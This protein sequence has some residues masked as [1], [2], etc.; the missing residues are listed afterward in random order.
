MLQVL[1]ALGGIGRVIVLIP[2]P[3]DVA[4]DLG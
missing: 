4:G 3:V 2:E 1:P